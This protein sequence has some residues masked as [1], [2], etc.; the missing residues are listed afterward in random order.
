MQA[1]SEMEEKIRGASRVMEREPRVDL[2]GHPNGER[3]IL[4][5]EKEGRAEVL[6]WFRGHSKLHKIESASL[7]HALAYEKLIQNGYRIGPHGYVIASGQ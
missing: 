1:E 7:A 2:P 4:L 5:F 6:L 3:A